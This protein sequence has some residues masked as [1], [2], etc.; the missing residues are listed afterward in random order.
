MNATTGKVRVF[1]RNN[2]TLR[3]A[4]GPTSLTATNF[5]LIVEGSSAIIDKPAGFTGIVIARQAA[6]AIS[7]CT[8]LT[9]AFFGRSVQTQPY[10]N[11]HLVGWAGTVGTTTTVSTTTTTRVATTVATTIAA[12]ATSTVPTTSPTN[13]TQWSLPTGVTLAQLVAL[14]GAGGSRRGR[15]KHPRARWLRDRGQ[16]RYRHD[17]PRRGRTRR[18]R[19]QRGQ[20]HRQGRRGRAGQRAQSR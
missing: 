13:V 11:Y 2:L 8:E 16:R 5:E 18:R 7:Q 1:I 9:G 17:D 10:Q 12:Q 6:L 3:G 19:L 20:R 14:A 15:R 4:L